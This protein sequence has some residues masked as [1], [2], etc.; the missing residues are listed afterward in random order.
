[1]LEERCRRRPSDIIDSPAWNACDRESFCSK[2]METSRRMG[3]RSIW[4]M[5]K[6]LQVLLQLLR[7]RLVKNR[8]YK[9]ES[10]TGGADGPF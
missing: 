6:V 2:L 7:G 4:H 5:I 1:M 3:S 8:E 9:F 10:R